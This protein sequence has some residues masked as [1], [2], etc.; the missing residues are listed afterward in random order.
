MKIEDRAFNDG[1]N[2]KKM[3]A[4]TEWLNLQGYD[5]DMKD[6][7]WMEDCISNEHKWRDIFEL[8]DGWAMFNIKNIINQFQ[9]RGLLSSGKK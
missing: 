4:M 1:L 2:D 8:M 5:F 3:I 6:G 7:L 9:D